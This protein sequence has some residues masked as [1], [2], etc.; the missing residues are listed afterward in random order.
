M[1]HS[2]VIQIGTELIDDEC[3]IKILSVNWSPYAIHKALNKVIDQKDIICNELEHNARNL[4][5]GRLFQH[6]TTS[7]DKLEYVQ[8]WR[9]ELIND[10]QTMYIGDACGDFLASC[11]ANIS[12]W[13]E[14]NEN[15]EFADIVNDKCLM[16]KELVF[17][18]HSWTLDV[19]CQH[20]IL[21]QQ[22]ADLL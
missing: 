19:I 16:N 18:A 14:T 11:C 3:I 22:T 4:S 20:T 15:E 13:M 8:E 2:H 10:E 12:V 21:A 9:S 1:N 6:C 5:T 7:E 17:A